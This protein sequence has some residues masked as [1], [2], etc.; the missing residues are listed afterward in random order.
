MLTGFDCLGLSSFRHY[1]QA[2]MIRGFVSKKEKGNQIDRVLYQF[3]RNKI[4]ILRVKNK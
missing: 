4:F 2:D 1:G 3:E